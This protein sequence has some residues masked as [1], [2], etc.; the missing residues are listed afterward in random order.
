MNGLSEKLLTNLFGISFACLA[1]AIPFSIAGANGAIFLGMIAW[2]LALA[3]RPTSRLAVGHVGRHPVFLVSVL[4][5]VSALPAVLISENITRAFRDWRSY[6]LLIVFFLLAFNLSTARLREGLFWVLLGSI[7]LSSVLAIIQYCGG[8]D[9]GFVHIRPEHRAGGTLY[10][11]TYAGILC[12]TIPLSISIL[13][14]ERKLSLPAALLSLGILLQTAALLFTLTRGAYLAFLGG[15]LALALI[16]RRKRVWLQ[17]AVLAGIL[18]LFVL[19][20]PADRDR[21]L[22]V[23]ALVKSPPDRNVRA[24]LVLWDVSIDLF[25]RHPIFGVGMGDYSI[26]AEGLLGEQRISTTVDSHNM[27]LQILATRGLFGFVPF[28]LFWIVVLRELFRMKTRFELGSFESY[29][30][31]GAIASTAALLLGALTENNMNDSE[32]L[33]AYLFIIGLASSAHVR[34]IIASDNKRG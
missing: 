23:P 29:L 13:Q 5:I 1:L 15:L 33:I 24:R 6:W 14:K 7:S 21:P 25:K 11:M 16:V 27:Y 28:A 31:A 4:L 17:A 3:T 20:N 18:A 10:P 8:L 32:V 9:I 26:A 34:S 19:W 2:L 22:S 12:Q 30:A